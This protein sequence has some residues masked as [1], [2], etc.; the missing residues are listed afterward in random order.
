V[1]LPSFKKAR[2]PVWDSS[3]FTGVRAG[4]EQ[5]A[6]RTTAKQDATTTRTLTS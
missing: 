5:D 3:G 2:I 4:A 1:V 6:S